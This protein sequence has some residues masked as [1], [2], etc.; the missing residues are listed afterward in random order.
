MKKLFML[1]IV[2]LM[3][4]AFAACGVKEKGETAGNPKAE[5]GKAA[6]KSVELLV[7]VQDMAFEKFEHY[8]QANGTVEAVK[9]AFISPET[10]G[11]VKKVHVREGQRVSKGKLLVSL[12]SDM[13]RS[14]IA[15]I[16]TQL[17]LAQTIYKRQTGL[18]DKKI[19]SEVQYLQAKTNKESLENRLKSLQAQLDMSQITAPVSGIVDDITLKEGELAMPGMQLLRLVN[20]DKVY[21]NA[22]VSEA[23]LAKV[24]SGDEAQVMFPSYPG[25]KIDT[26]VHRVGHV[27]KSANRTFLVQLLLDNNE[28]QFKPNMVSVVRLRDFVAESA[29]VVP[30]IVIKNDLEG[31]YLYILEKENNQ[32]IARKVYVETGMS[33]GSRTMVTKGLKPGQQVIVEGY[34]LVKNGMHVKLKG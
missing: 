27:V 23:Y 8:F 34:H 4:L 11:Q 6:P 28:E 17:E 26:L 19:G 32:T 20:L 29:L 2:T 5:E 33:E 18:W 25:L 22:D 1:I 16:K 15:E 24:R 7:T 31:S 12:N 30:S 13:I 21:I 10:N 3:I 9:E 14:S